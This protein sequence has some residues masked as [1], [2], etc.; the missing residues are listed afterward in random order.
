MSA[1]STESTRHILL[2]TLSNIGD[3]LM[4]TPVLEALHR[5]YPQAVIDIVTDARASD[6]FESCP[7]RGEIILKHKGWRGTLALVKRLR[8]T[9][10]DLVV[11]LRTDGLTLLLRARRKLT[12][13][14]NRNTGGHAVERHFGIITQDIRL[15]E[16]PPQQV[17]L[18]KS[19]RTFAQQR[20]A[21]LPGQR[22][23]ALGPG[24]RWAPKCWP[25]ENYVDLANQLTEYFDAIILLGSKDDMNA[26]Q[27]ISKS[28]VLPHQNL[29]GKTDLLQAAAIL[30]QAQ[31]FVGSDSG[32]GHLAAASGTPTLTVFGPG[33]PERYH[34][35]HPQ[36]RWIQSEN[37]E[38]KGITVSQVADTIKALPW[39]RV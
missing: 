20:L 32:L 2:I 6:L 37:E 11:D 15:A 23:L 4:T 1:D 5:Q 14:G 18:T 25:P 36:A 31:L 38:I 21:K 28:L 16:I 29:A 9:H 24:A 35:W 13:R 19:Q 34:P 22:W 7:Y 3:A 17:W 10:Y 26:C 8:V 33:D 27:H 39:N 12:R 30:E